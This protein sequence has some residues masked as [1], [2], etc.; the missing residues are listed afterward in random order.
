MVRLALAAQ[1]A[2]QA[3]D[4]WI[5]EEETHMPI[6]KGFRQLVDEAMAQVTTYSVEQ[7]RAVMSKC[8][9]Q[10]FAESQPLFFQRSALR[11]W[12]LMGLLHLLLL[13]CACSL[14]KT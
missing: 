10:V 7:V 4:N 8:P 5:F 1:A 12:F 11:G 14:C 3:R 6:T 13:R 2:L 9:E